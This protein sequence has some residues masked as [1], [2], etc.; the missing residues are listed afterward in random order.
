MFD[1][2]SSIKTGKS[3]EVRIHC[4]FCESRGQSKD[5]KY[6][7][8]VNT[9]KAVAHCFRCGYSKHNIFKDELPVVEISNDFSK[10]ECA[11]SNLFSIRKI[12]SYDLEKISWKLSKE[13]TPI[14]YKY[15]VARGFNDTD[16]SKYDLRV[17][18]D[19]LE[20]GTTVKKWS[21]RVLFPYKDTGGEVLFV[22]GRSYAGKNPKYLNSKGDRSHAVY[23]LADVT[24]GVAGIC[25][26]IIDAIAF[27]RATGI[28]GVCGLGKEYTEVQIQ[29]IASKCHTVYE[30]LDGDVDVSLRVKLC[31]K[32][33]NYGVK[34]K[35][36][37]LPNGEDPSSFSHNLNNMVNNA[38]D[39]NPTD[40]LFK[41]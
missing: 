36:I 35:N 20:E 17:G 16:I 34:V 40:Y 24:D 33:L 2:S 15:M 31:M 21:G 39:F 12:P 3:E 4:P 14:A 7:M 38:K 9:R 10:L 32:F 41:V 6:K 19:Y 25:E 18:R 5:T 13:K 8:Y 22:V 28:P 26:G 37:N 30:S 27:K 29:K 23:G 11:L 1:L